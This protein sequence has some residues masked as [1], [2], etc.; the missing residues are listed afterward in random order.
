MKI[1]AV[2]MDMDG[3]LL[4]KSQVAVSRRNMAAI[5]KAISKGVHVIPCTGR[6]F[7]MLP[8]Q[9]LTQEGLR[10]FVL[11]H[12]ARAYDKV[13]DRSLYEDL[14][15]ADEAATLMESL[16]GKGLYNEVA[17][18][19]TVY[20]EK[21]ITEPFDLSLIPEHHVWYV[22]DNCFTAVENPAEHFRKNGIGVEKMNL[23]NIPAGLQNELYDLVTASGFIGHTRPGAGPHLEF[24]H[25]GLDKLCAVRSIL[26]RIGVSFEETMAIGDSSSD[27]AI[28]EAAGLGVAMGNAPDNIKAYAD[29]V[30]GLNTDDGLAAA[31]E[32]YVL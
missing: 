18:E 22:R 16:Q 15:P 3:T 5:Q 23:Y 32:A 14:I 26:E 1:R 12:G 30:T 2:L 10:Y 31:F 9:L 27:V 13:E 17:A 29:V 11:S 4:G 25:K 19:G 21:A 8:P 20:F 6:V 7:D 28:L 24:S